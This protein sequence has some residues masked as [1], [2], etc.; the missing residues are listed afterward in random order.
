MKA[1]EFTSTLKNNF[2]HIPKSMQGELISK[3]DK[4]I[5]VIILIDDVEIKDDLVF[6]KSAKA[7]FLKGYADSDGIYDQ[8]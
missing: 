3:A 5:R 2:I 1:L 6:E 8:G 7:Q 4:E